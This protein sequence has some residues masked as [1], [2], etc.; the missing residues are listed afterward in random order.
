MR[1]GLDSTCKTCRKV[2]ARRRAKINPGR[3]H[4][5][6]AGQY[7][8]MFEAQGGV[9]AICRKPQEGRASLPVDHDHACCDRPFS[10]GRCVRALLC[11]RCNA[12]LGHFND[13]PELLRVA[14]GYLAAG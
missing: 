8:A 3:K 5:L 12:G 14:I 6:T 1:H 4:G 13:D 10:C 11:H 2:E 9:C 7:W